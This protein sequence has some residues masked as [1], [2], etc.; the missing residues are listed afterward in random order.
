MSNAKIVTVRDWRIQRILGRVLNLR[1]C[2]LTCAL[3]VIIDNTRLNLISSPTGPVFTINR[4]YFFSILLISLL[5]AT[6]GAK[7]EFSTSAL[8]ASAWSASF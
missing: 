4:G 1:D 3:A 7:V 8:I 6:F 5:A 2:L